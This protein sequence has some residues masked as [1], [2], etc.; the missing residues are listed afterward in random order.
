M[1][2][3]KGGRFERDIC[4]Q[5]SLW[6]SKAMFKEERDDLFWRTAGSGAR[7]TTRMKENKKTTNSCGDICS[8]DE[9]SSKLTKNYFFELKRGFTSSAKSK[10]RS[11]SLTEIVDKMNAIKPPLLIE[12]LEKAKK[13]AKQH[14]I[15]NVVI[16]FKRDRRGSCILFEMKTWS[17]I[18]ENNGKWIYPNNGPSCICHINNHEFK[19]VGFDDF[20][21]W[22][23]PQALFYKVEKTLKRR[24]EKGKYKKGKYGT[25]NL[26]N[27]EK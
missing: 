6:Y 22:C 17:K 4:K 9:R 7:A 26:K 10:K 2:S 1:K 24:E 3:L 16:I 27:K 14:G 15:P 19:V 13:E 5:L 21:Y 11:I 8:L 23:K 20:L 25:K 12:W 18:E